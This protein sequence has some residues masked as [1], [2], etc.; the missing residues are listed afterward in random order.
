MFQKTKCKRVLYDNNKIKMST[1]AEKRWCFN[2]PRV[3][4]YNPQS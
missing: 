2:S 4:L 3:G 1:N